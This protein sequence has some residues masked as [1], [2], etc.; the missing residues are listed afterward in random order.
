MIS[1]KI[2]MNKAMDDNKVYPNEVGK[3]YKDSEKVT[4]EGWLLD[5]T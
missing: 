2:N 3:F 1:N 5:G 4:V